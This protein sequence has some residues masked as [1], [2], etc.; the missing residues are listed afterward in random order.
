VT[1]TVVSPRTVV[2]AWLADFQAA[3]TARDVD[4]AAALFAAESFWRDLVAF[5]WN[6]RTVEGPAGV[7]DM[8]RS[9]LDA[10]DPTG[11]RT[12]EEPTEAGGVTDAW[13]EFET[14]AGRG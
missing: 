8:L 9:Q 3:L 12:T 6:I 13:V 7:A 14:A 1:Q 2:D 11:F 5:T 10:V 4:A